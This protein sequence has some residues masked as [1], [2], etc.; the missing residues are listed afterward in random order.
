MKR[1]T[2]ALT[3]RIATGLAVVALLAAPIVAAQPP[4]V[5]ETIGPSGIRL[6]P[7]TSW[8][9][10]RLVIVGP[11]A[12][13][14][15]SFFDGGGT[16]DVS[17]VG[18]DGNLLPDG[19]YQFELRFRAAQPT[20][21]AGAAPDSDVHQVGLALDQIHA[22]SFRLENGL[23]V[24][25]EAD[26]KSTHSGSH[27]ELSP[28]AATHHA[29][30]VTMTG[31]LCVG[32]TDCSA[33]YTP[34]DSIEIIDS[35]IPEITFRDDESAPTRHW[36]LEATNGSIHFTDV[37]SGN[38]NV[39]TLEEG[40]PTSSIY[41]D[42]EFGL[43]RVGL[44][45]ATPASGLHLA[46]DT[47]ITFEEPGVATWRVGTQSDVGDIQFE[48]V[49]DGAGG[50]VDNVLVLEN[51]FATT[52]SGTGIGMYTGNPQAGLHI[53]SPGFELGAGDGSAKVLV[54]ENSPTPA[55]RTLF[56]LI[57]NG[58][59]IFRVQNTD[60]SQIF[61]FKVSAGG[62]VVN[63]PGHPG[64]QYALTPGGRFLVGIA[65]AQAAIEVNGDM[66][67]AGALTENS[68]R[69]AKE[70]LEEVSAEAILAKVRELPI[71]RWN[72]IDNRDSVKHLGP[73]AQDFHALFGLGASETGIATLDTSGVA[74]A[75]IQG[76]AQE[77]EERDRRIDQLEAKLVQLHSLLV[78]EDPA[79]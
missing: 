63:R 69:N 70:N 24:P 46:Q 37:L 71:S 77:L 19:A 72:Y 45:T 60:A 28:E 62:F 58:V 39:F 1:E 14:S 9:E 17:G 33:G 65:G 21:T 29:S 75:A 40:V 59:N 27:G 44:G 55:A 7:T 11:G 6:Q 5:I 79:R 15:E 73:M 49:D 53:A 31:R 42:S 30:A 16:I 23:L 8:E 64:V 54:T 51:N 41:V 3:T 68:D 50:S 26:Q 32:N 78:P 2:T 66:E 76:L 18:P 43:G 48:L 13:R 38:F 10:A 4:E 34:G 20:G 52:P 74:L 67:I 36:E 22:G 47:D 61:D 56:E 35:G 12:Y 57:N 25:A